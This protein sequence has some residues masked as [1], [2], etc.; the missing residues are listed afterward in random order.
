MKKKQQH[1][2][3]NK[4]HLGREEEW[5]NAPQQRIMISKLLLCCPSLQKPDLVS[6][7]RNS[8]C[9]GW[10]QE[11]FHF[12]VLQ[13]PDENNH[14]P[15]AFIYSTSPPTS[16]IDLCNKTSTVYV[17]LRLGKSQ[18]PSY[19]WLFDTPRPIR[20]IEYKTFQNVKER[21]FHNQ[22]DTSWT[23]TNLT[24]TTV[25]AVKRWPVVSS[26]P[27]SM[28]RRLWTNKPLTYQSQPTQRESGKSHCRVCLPYSQPI[29]RCCEQ[30][31]SDESCGLKT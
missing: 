22:M 2:T 24:S 30:Y 7:K 10:G 18:T 5:R 8:L 14:G 27:C 12:S 6:W 15:S 9:R 1:A 21:V 25:N 20:G 29:R 23:S 17:R 19:P 4:G 11:V 13:L 3:E 31:S 26:T 28:S 16:L